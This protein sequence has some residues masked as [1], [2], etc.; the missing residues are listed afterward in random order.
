MFVL[1]EPQGMPFKPSSSKF[2][3]ERNS[4]LLTEATVAVLQE[5]S[6]CIEENEFREQGV[7][8]TRETLCTY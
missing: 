6:L 7:L 3:L 5:D 1:L 8:S 4:C 2:R